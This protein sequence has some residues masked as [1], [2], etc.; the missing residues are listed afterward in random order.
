MAKN[1]IINGV[2]YSDVPYVNIPLASGSGNAK[3]VD[4]DSSDTASAA[5]ASD[6]RAGKKAWVNG[7][8]VTGTIPEK[9]STDVTVS[10][11]T[12]TVPAGVYDDSVTKSVADGT[13]TPTATISGDEIG[14][15]VSDYEI[16]ITPGATVEA[17]YVTG[18]KTGTQIKKY[19]KV[20]DKIA[21]PTTSAQD[22]TPTAGKLLKKVTVAAVNVAATATESDVLSGK[23]FYSGS[24][25]VRTGTATVP[26]VGQDSTT[27]VLSIS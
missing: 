11:K 3:F 24:L 25:T 4:T 20:E 9:S 16:D 5:A 19:I 8:E 22:I 17:G 27:K 23:T 6:L 15:T 21:T 2:T 14:D 26:I 13:V 10:G 18:D 7:A 1:V 12:I